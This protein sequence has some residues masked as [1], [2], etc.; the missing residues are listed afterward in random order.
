MIA[1]IIFIN[2][3][4]NAFF[5]LIKGEIVISYRICL[6]SEGGPSDLPHP[7]LGVVSDKGEGSVKPLKA[8]KRQ[9][10]HLL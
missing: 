4:A 6:T 10:S 1:A 7:P 5:A 3:P 8:K 9:K 2:Y